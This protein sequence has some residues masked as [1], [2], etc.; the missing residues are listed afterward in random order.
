MKR[1]EHRLKSK[2]WNQK[3]IKKSIRI[4]KNGKKNRE[5]HIQVLDKLIYIFI[6]IVAVFAN[7]VMSIFL[8][9]L[10]IVMESTSSFFLIIISLALI[11][12]VIFTFLIYEIESLEKKHH[13][14]LGIIVPLIALVNIIIIV[15]ISN[16]LLDQ[17]NTFKVHQN[18]IIVPVLYII[19]FLLPYIISL[20]KNKQYKLS[21][22]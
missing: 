16:R 18:P 13:I 8:I 17:L 19:F 4:L 22:I 7:I 20:L 15:F 12:G 10:L 14:L 6:F 3:D 9:P 11:S 5:K 1:L 2:G 21:K